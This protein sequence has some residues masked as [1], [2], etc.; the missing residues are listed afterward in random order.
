MDSGRRGTETVALVLARLV[1]RDVETTVGQ[2]VCRGEAGDACTEDDHSRARAHD[3]GVDT[4]VMTHLTAV[5]SAAPVASE[6]GLRH[7]RRRSVSCA[8]SIVERASDAQ[9]VGLHC[10][11]EPDRCVQHVE[12]GATGGA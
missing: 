11:S 5:R 8:R 2:F 6:P 3:A 10:V 12:D 9:H 1:H 7:G 4:Q